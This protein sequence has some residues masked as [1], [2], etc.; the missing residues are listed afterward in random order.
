MPNGVQ[1]DIF[2]HCTLHAKL[3][4]DK[5]SKANLFDTVDAPAQDALSQWETSQL[6]KAI[7]IQLSLEEAEEHRVDMEASNKLID[8]RLRR[9]GLRRVEVLADGNCQFG[10]VIRS[11]HLDIAVAQLRSEVV[12]HLAPLAKLFQEQVE[13]RFQGK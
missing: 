5:N 4:N 1:K 7:T 12:K 10:A 3:A 6:E 13:E 11:R 8:A 2:V 9:E